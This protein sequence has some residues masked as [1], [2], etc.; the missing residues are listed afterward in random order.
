MKHTKYV[1]VDGEKVYVSDEV[2]TA[3]KKQK[4]RMEYLER[5]DDEYLD[6]NFTS[7]FGIENIPDISVDVEKIVYTNMF[8]EKLKVAMESLSDEEVDIVRQIYYENKTLRQIAKMKNLSH[9]AIIKK[10][11]LCIL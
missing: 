7:S 5:L 9:P 3:L 1:Y 4:N 11:L 8:I 6:R 2:Y 10:R